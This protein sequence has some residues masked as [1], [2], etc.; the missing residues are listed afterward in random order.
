MSKTK[1]VNIALEDLSYTVGQ[2]IKQVKANSELPVDIP[3]EALNEL[4]GR[5]LIKE[6]DINI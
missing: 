4:V 2:E 6:F 1:K 3:K 5:G